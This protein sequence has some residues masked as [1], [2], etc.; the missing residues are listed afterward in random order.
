MLSTSSGDDESD[1]LGL[2]KLAILESCY[3]IVERCIQFLV[4]EEEEK[5][6]WNS[7][8]PTTLLCLRDSFVDIVQTGISLLKYFEKAREENGG[9]LTDGGRIIM[10]E[11]IFRL[12]STWLSVDA[13][14][15]AETLLN[16]MQA[17]EYVILLLDPK[18]RNIALSWSILYL[19]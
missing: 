13:V 19:P 4:D 17:I 6:K 2:N 1:E 18:F 15:V 7:L 3:G 12:L 10:L 9:K 5:Y 8:K 14:S 16:N 11:I